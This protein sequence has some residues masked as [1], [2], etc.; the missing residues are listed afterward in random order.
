MASGEDR[1]TYFGKMPT[2]VLGTCYLGYVKAWP[3]PGNYPGDPGQ[4]LFGYLPATGWE[5]LNLGS[6][7]DCSMYMTL[8]IAGKV[9]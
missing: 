5:P 9:C 6:A 2:L 4:A 7:I 3:P 8:E 1:Y